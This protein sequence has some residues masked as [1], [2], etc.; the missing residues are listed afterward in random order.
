[1]VALHQGS[2]EVALK[3]AAGS[4]GLLE[5][6]L[7]AADVSS[8]FPE[9]VPQVTDNG[10]EASWHLGQQGIMLN[11]KG[12]HAALE[13]VALSRDVN[14]VGL[15]SCQLV[16][17]LPDLLGLLCLQYSKACLPYNGPSTTT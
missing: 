10:T 13:S 4:L 5:A 12:I 3:A 8:G 15:S 7:Q 11:P 16:H 9:V 6:A 1:M 2:A 14:G 17:Q